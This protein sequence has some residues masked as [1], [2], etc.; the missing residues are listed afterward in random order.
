MIYGDKSMYLCK[1]FDFGFILFENMLDVVVV[2][3]IIQCDWGNCVNC[4]NV[5]IKYMLECVGVDNFKVEV[6]KCVGV[7]F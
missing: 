3:V 6:E 5:K 1:V 7:I 2:V 4:K